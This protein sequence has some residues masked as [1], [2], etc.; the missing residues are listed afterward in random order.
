MAGRKKKKKTFRAVTAVKE[1]AR[2]RVGAPPPGQIVGG[3]KEEAGKAQNDAGQAIAGRS[4]MGARLVKRRGNG[5]VALHEKSADPG[6][7]ATARPTSEY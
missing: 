4:V 3:E 1:L 6:P 7:G 5:S 2:E